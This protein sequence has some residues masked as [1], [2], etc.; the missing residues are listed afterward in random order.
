MAGKKTQEFLSNPAS[1]TWK[2]G[3]KITL[4]LWPFPFTS[5]GYPIKKK[6]LPEKPFNLGGR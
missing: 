3:Y 1:P 2:Q 4:F 5:K 6:Q